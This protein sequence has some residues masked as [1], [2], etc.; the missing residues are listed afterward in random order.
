[1]PLEITVT[2]KSAEALKKQVGEGEVSEAV[3]SAVDSY[4]VAK[5]EHDELAKLTKTA[6]KHVDE[7]ADLLRAHTEGTV[8]PDLPLAIHGHEHSIEVGAAPKA[9]TD[10]NLDK[11]IEIL[12]VE[13][14]L[15]IAKVGITDLRKYLTPEQFEEACTEELSGTRRIKVID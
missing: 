14:F 8:T 10:V 5:A 3:R 9:V 12:G 7:N 4:V 2:D 13:A 15:K 1:M 6:K 11:V